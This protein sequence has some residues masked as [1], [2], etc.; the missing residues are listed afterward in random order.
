MKTMYEIPSKEAAEKLL[1]MHWRQYN[2]YIEANA[3]SAFRDLV[4]PILKRRNWKLEV[5]QV[6]WSFGAT[7]REFR[8]DLAWSEED[9]DVCALIEILTL[10]VPGFRQ[11]DFGSFMPSYG[12]PELINNYCEE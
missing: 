7:G 12:F 5:T 8:P 6:Y 11:D 1:D 2:S 3:K 10:D 9:Q 4:L